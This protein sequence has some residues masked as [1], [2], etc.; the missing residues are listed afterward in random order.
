MIE[1]Y[2]MEYATYLDS[3]PEDK[4]EEELASNAPKRR[5]RP[6]QPAVETKDKLKQTKIKDM[7]KKPDSSVCLLKISYINKIKSKLLKL[8]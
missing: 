3:L 7:F 5:A 8:H 4:R 2:K 6:E 1:N